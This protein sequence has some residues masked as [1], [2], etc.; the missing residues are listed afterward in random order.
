MLRMIYGP[1]NDNG[2]WRTR[3]SN[4]LYLLYNELDKVKVMTAG[5]L[6]W[7]GHLFRM[8]ELDPCS[9]LNHLKLEGT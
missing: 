2:V 7:L 8:Q 9:K 3:Y 5:R 6:G 4:V 1:I